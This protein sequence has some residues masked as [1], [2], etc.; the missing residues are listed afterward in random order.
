MK[1][2]V[3][4]TYHILFVLFLGLLVNAATA[5][6]LQAQCAATA[7]PSF[8][9]SCASDYFTSITASGSSYVISTVNVT[10][11]Y[12][13]PGG[14]NVYYDNY[15]TQGIS[16]PPGATINMNISRVDGSGYA[17]YLS[18]F[19]DWNN[20]GIYEPGELAGT[21]YFFAA[22][23]ASTIYSFVVP[24]SAVTG[25]N[26]H[27]RVFL[28][29]SLI[30][31][32]CDGNY[33][34]A[35]DLYFNVDCTAPAI[36]ATPS[37]GSYCTGSAGTAITASGAGSGAVIYTWSPAAGLSATTGATVAASPAAT[38]AYTVTGTS[39]LGCS[40][41]ATSTITVYTLSPTISSAGAVE[42]SVCQG[43]PLHL[44]AA[45]SASASPYTYIWTGP[46]GYSHTTGPTFALTNAVTVSSVPGFPAAPVYT[47]T[48]TDAH[49]CAVTGTA[50]TTVDPLPTLYTVYG[51]GI[52]CVG[53]AGIDVQLAGSDV[54]AN[55]Q[56]YSGSTAVGGIITG[57]GGSLDFGNQVAG[58]YSVSGVYSVTG[59][60]VG[61]AGTATIS[62]VSPPAVITGS[63]TVCAGLTTTLSDATAGGT[64]SISGSTVATVDAGGVVTGIA[65]GN[66]IVTYTAS[67]C[68]VA[69][70]VT[71][72]PLA[73]ITGSAGVCSGSTETLGDLAA[74]G[75]WSS[76]NAGI[77]GI[78][79][80]GFLNAIMAGNT[81]ITYLLPTGCMATLPVTVNPLPSP[82]SG[83]VNICPSSSATLSD[84]APSGTWSSGNT[85]IAVVGS[86][87][88]IVTGIG[89]G[90]TAITFTLPTGCTTTAPA[91]I[92]TPPPA[93][94]QFSGLCLGYSAPL[95]DAVAGGTWSSSVP[96]TANIG[97]SGVVSGLTL[98][99]S[100]ITY[101]APVTGCIATHVVTVEPLPQIITGPMTICAGPTVTLSDATPGGTWTCSTPFIATINPATGAVTGVSDGVALVTYTIGTGCIQTASVTVNPLPSPIIGSTQFCVGLT[102]SL[103][104]PI[105]GGSWSSS[106]PAI[107]SIGS[108]SAVVAGIST[109]TAIITYELITGCYITKQVTVNPLPTAILG[110]VPV[111]TGANIT[112][113]GTPV[114]G[115][116]LSGNAAIATVGTS[117]GIVSGL[118]AGTV[119]V[120]YT[121]PSGCA[122]TAIVT[123]NPSPAGIS[124]T[125]NI[126]LGLTGTLSDATAGGTWASSFA[127]VATV[128]S[129]GIVT[130]T[131]TG[132]ATITYGLT[133][134]C[135]ATATV[136]V[137]PLPSPITGI[138]RVCAGS[139]TS[140]SD[141]GGGTWNSGAPTVASIAAGAGIVT[142]NA[143]GTAPITYTLPT[144]CTTTAVVTVNP[145]PPAISGSTTV[146][147]GLTV[148]LS[149]AAPGGAWSSGNPAVA[150][151][152]SGSGLVTGV[153]AGSAVISYTLATGCVGTTIVTV[154]PLPLAITGVMHV[155]AGL[156]T[157]LTDAIPGGT[158]SSGSPGIAGISITG[159]VTG[160]AAGT[161]NITYTV[162][163][164]CIVT[165]IVTVNPLPAAISGTAAICAGS[166][167]TLSDASA[168][169]TWL[170]SNTPVAA[171]GTG[172]LVTAVSAGTSGITYTL[173]TGCLA[174][175]TITVNPLPLTI[176]G[177]LHL[178]VGADVSLTDA[179]AGGLW[180][181]IASASGIAA[182]SPF[183]GNVSG[184]GAGTAT[185]TYTLPTGCI[186]LSV[187]T[188][189]PL[190]L[191]ITG[192]AN[193]CAGSA[194]TLSDIST[195]G[196][197]SSS[198]TA[199]ATIGITTG[200]VTGVSNGVA[201]I[202][203]ALPTG[204]ISTIAFTVNPLPAAIAGSRSLCLTATSLLSDASTGGTWSL[205]PASRDSIGPVSG[206]VTADSVGIATVTYTLPTGCIATAVVTVNPVPSA[207]L[208]DTFPICQG[209][210]IALSDS[211]YGGIWSSANPG[212]ANVI[213]GTG[214]V[215]GVAAGTVNISYTLAT[216]CGVAAVVTVNPLFPIS[217]SRNI[218]LGTP[219]DLTDLA[220][221][222][223]WSSG[224]PAVA[225]IGSVTGVVTGIASGA[226]NITYHLGTGCMATTS[227]TVNPLPVSYDVTGGGSFCAGGTGVDIGL[228]GSENGVSYQLRYSGSAIDTLPGSGSALDF[229]L[230]TLPG[231]YTV[232]ATD[233]ITGC[234][235]AMTASAAIT[236]NPTVTPF[237]SINAISGTTICAGALADF[238]AAP[239][240]GG[241]TPLYQWSVNGINVASGAVYGYVPL[242]GDVVS[243]ELISNAACVIPDSAI[244]SVTMTTVS[245][246]TPSVF[247]SVSPGDS[248]CPGIPVTV[249]PSTTTGG[250]SPTFQWIK[251][252]IEVGSGLTY[253]FLPTDGDNVFC[254][255]HSDMACAMPDTVHSSNNINMHVPPIY[256]PDVT[257]AAYPGT[258]IEAADT[259]TLVAFVVFSGLSFSYQW[260]IN[261]IPVAGA[262]TDTFKSSLFNNMDV[263]SCEV[264]GTS[265]CG[266]AT[267]SA[268]VM[269][270]DTIALG[271]HGVQPL[272]SDI[273]LVPNPN[274]GTF[275]IRGTLPQPGDLKMVITDMLGQVVYTG[276]AHVYGGRINEQLQLTGTL[277]NGMYT[278]ELTSGTINKLLHFVVG[279]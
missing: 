186:T 143:A 128:G 60:S 6:N 194:A 63:M 72:Y 148:S 261:N 205:N 118:S 8:T 173:P 83:A 251:N 184:L 235:V 197:W 73:P 120:T 209:F 180:S 112:L 144:G 34:Q 13:P 57:T 139:T 130:G 47:V 36:T 17:A 147:T 90:T 179:S 53:T 87:T 208:A 104:D 247:L 202:T 246:V 153:F 141:A 76:S 64:W 149:D 224:S 113:S 26:L 25:T 134:G 223:T 225:T 210:D 102:S 71:V 181:I 239:V 55:Y 220:T 177:P 269:I 227:I 266:T 116:W 10:G 279:Q 137:Y 219:N 28:T 119:A 91:T 98:G 29:E 136:A 263:V 221:G 230:F 160:I 132:T 16:A 140:L 75:T 44:D 187:I 99:T 196:T 262:I 264:T 176:S 198:N 108:T 94:L 11:T 206:I 260:N 19:V 162:A 82:I 245:G 232:L 237:V 65:A 192:A 92:F 174:T 218:C 114:G 105:E 3:S 56:L 215:A 248:V 31:V 43:S 70:I 41:T 138:M 183:S 68:T 37:A 121:L 171:M 84:P 151:I 265:V 18:V 85:A 165:A 106:A 107:A 161:A 203:Y 238:N 228:N 242:N 74:G 9:S 189:N 14:T 27:M 191:A 89:P 115:T 111:C 59:C 88:G 195:G 217:G 212:I 78:T 273:R 80:T 124:G 22:L 146:C 142:G 79:G 211:T 101:T 155:C 38:T 233:S 77:A 166:T 255:M 240:N 32:P 20:D 86:G 45:I 131:A 172:G 199:F 201:V 258:R 21:T 267:R 1:R 54:G 5:N 62:A 182:V 229:G 12:C 122:L 213:A 35:A 61:M 193:I 135:F 23:A 33:G 277:A 66:A 67:G 46:G 103:F 271:V 52:Y 96:S 127:F 126:C 250:V 188:V 42:P 185:V 40:N 2:A 110:N 152:G 39:A 129:T 157:A 58:I 158:W 159:V 276:T 93:I 156:T 236:V 268:Q 170:S 272:V 234:S 109:G 243:V 259:V 175:L 214:V 48:I 274:N 200:M 49:H 4:I 30:T 204:C 168:G 226:T 207:I 252:G 244:A 163:S 249:I 123:V 15:A 278:L 117:S 241:S 253:T 222:G 154:Q 231:A 254:R 145:L 164:G 50:T 270:V 256:V 167:T 257:I 24:A 178:C 169:G 125:A 7:P 275:T 150:T 97:S 69:T 100:T 95:S 81:T 190:P 51:N 133:T 216:G